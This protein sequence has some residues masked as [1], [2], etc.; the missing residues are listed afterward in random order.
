[1]SRIVRL[2]LRI[3]DNVWIR[4]IV[5]PRALFVVLANL[6]SKFICVRQTYYFV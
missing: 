5:P 4:G 2:S 3:G 1:L 6:A